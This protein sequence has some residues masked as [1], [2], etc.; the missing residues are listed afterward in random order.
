MTEHIKVKQ[1]GAVL[2][3]VFARPDKRN[4]LSNAMYRVA[5]EALDAAQKD[6]ATRETPAGT[7]ITLPMPNAASARI[8]PI[9]TLAF[10]LAGRQGWWLR[11]RRAA[12]FSTR[13]TVSAAKLQSRARSRNAFR[14]SFVS[15]SSAVQIAGTRGMWSWRLLRPQRPNRTSPRE[16]VSVPK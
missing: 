7:A 5:T 9:F 4:A 15:V 1:D 13:S 14:A 16:D 10:L 6:S 8:V 12:S 11:S 2:E 3:I